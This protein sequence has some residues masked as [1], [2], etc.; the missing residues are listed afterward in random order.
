MLVKSNGA[1]IPL[2]YI[3]TGVD[4]LD[5]ES[6]SADPG[7]TSYIS[8]RFLKPLNNEGYDPKFLGCER[9][10]AE[11]ATISQAWLKMNLQP[12]SWYMMRAR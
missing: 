1:R 3:F 5:K 8:Q 7:A 9:D 6:N 2:Y 10:K 12:C 4:S 11:N